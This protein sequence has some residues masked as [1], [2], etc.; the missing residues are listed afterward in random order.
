M[1]NTQEEI[2]RLAAYLMKNFPTAIKGGLTAV[3]VAILLLNDL[4]KTLE[5]IERWKISLSI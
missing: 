3:D 5:D 2:T 4:K 1:P